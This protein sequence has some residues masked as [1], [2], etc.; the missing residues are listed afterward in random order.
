M[1]PCPGLYGKAQP[2]NTCRK[3]LNVAPESF[4]V[5]V[6]DQ[7]AG[8]PRTRWRQ[9]VRHW[10]LVVRVLIGVR[11]TVPVP[12]LPAKEVRSLWQ[13]DTVVQPEAGLA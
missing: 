9:R 5:L 8:R 1:R 2:G 4:L 13:P 7:C 3:D 11:H 10:A 12:R 6:C